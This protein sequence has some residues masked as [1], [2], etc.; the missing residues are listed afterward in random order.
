MMIQGSEDTFI[1]TAGGLFVAWSLDVPSKWSDWVFVEVLLPQIRNKNLGNN[2]CKI[3]PSRAMTT[4]E[5]Q[6]LRNRQLLFWG[7]KVQNAPWALV[8]CKTASSVQSPSSAWGGFG[9]TS[10]AIGV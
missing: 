4:V 9:D 3:V 7:M 6:A 10:H 2:I 8:L 5:V 1:R